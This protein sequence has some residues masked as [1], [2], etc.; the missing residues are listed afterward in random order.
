MS[1]PNI[2]RPVFDLFVRFINSGETS[3][4]VKSQAAR[5]IGGGNAKCS[6]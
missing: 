6:L 1:D 5:G 4:E 2:N 3:Q